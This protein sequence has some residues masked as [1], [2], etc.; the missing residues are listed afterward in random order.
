MNP[1]YVVNHP[2]MQKLMGEAFRAAPSAGGQ[3]AGESGITIVNVATRG[4]AEEEA[5]KA[6]AQGRQAIINEVLGEMSKGESS[7]IVK[8]MR[9][10]QR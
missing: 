10:T 2:Q 4:Q 7:R 1:E 6:R 3:A 5:G 9:T 8:M